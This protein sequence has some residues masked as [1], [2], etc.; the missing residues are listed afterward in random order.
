MM[1][2]KVFPAADSSH[3]CLAHPTPN[4]QITICGD[5]AEEWRDALSMPMYLKE[6]QSMANAPLATND[7]MTNWILVDDRDSPDARQIL[8]SCESFRKR[9]LLSASDGRVTEVIVHG[10][11]SVFC[12]SQYRGRGYP[13]RMM[14]E[15][16]KQLRTWQTADLRCIGSILYSD[17][18]KDYY[19]KLGWQART[20]NMHVE[21]KLAPSSQ[22]SP[23]RVLLAAD[24]PALCEKDEAR[25]RKSIAIPAKVM[26]IPCFAIVPDLDHL[27]WHFA[28]E[29]FA[30]NH[31]FGRYPQAKGAIAGP[32]GNQVWATW[33][34]RYYNHPSIESSN[35]VLYILRF[36][37]EADESGVHQPGKAREKLPEDKYEEQVRYL[38]AVIRA[39]QREAFEWK[40]DTIQLWD[41]SPLVMKMLK[42]MN[43]ANKVVE[44]ENNSIASALWYNEE[45]EVSSDFGPLWLHNEHYA[46]C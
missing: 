36:V 18:G 14:R 34:H 12:S 44:R 5:T 11:A 29:E 6:S 16:V 40:L 32:A 27:G 21:V 9:A 31:L 24:L 20:S 13:K 19:T 26:D 22:T 2:T 42:D 28:K 7:G 4:E 45:G 17:I 46:W 41:P 30:C 25:L 37:M 33:T 3:L 15:L 23:A 35:N 1:S 39:A 38:E 43:L 8:S 10:I